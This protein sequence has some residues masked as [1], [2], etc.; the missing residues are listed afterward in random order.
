MTR[1]PLP[2]LV[3]CLAAGGLVVGFAVEPQRAWAAL[4]CAAL[5]ALSTSLFGAVFV[6]LANICGGTWHVAFRR[7]PE[8]MSSGIA[9]FGVVVV[10]LLAWRTL[11]GGT[12]WHPPDEPGTLWFKAWWLQP[13]FMV[14][15]SVG[16]VAVW[17]IGA[18]WLRS[19]SLA[20]DVRESRRSISHV[21][22][23]SAVFAALFAVTFSLAA[24]DWLMA[25]E[26]TWYST[27][28]GIYWFS[29]LMTGG[30]A[31]LILLALSLRDAGP[32]RQA[33]TDEH[34]HDLGKL[35][36]G[37]CCFWMYIWY[38]Q[39]MLIWYAHLPE[40][41][42]YFVPRLTGAWSVVFIVNVGLNWGL[43]FLL[44]LPRTSKRNP[45]LL[46]RVAVV[47]LV[48]RAVDLYLAA[49]PEVVGPYLIVGALE[50]AAA[51]LIAFVAWSL[52]S[53][54]FSS[55]PAVPAGSPLLRESLEYHA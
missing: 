18:T 46:R 32:L 52:W 44:L 9:P 47:V 36:F 3:A 6:A 12:A 43:P 25:L 20:E 45:T 54:S 4:Y 16:Y 14:A 31:T 26:P 48:G 30:L 27:V 28:W 21:Q 17:M 35:L 29:G 37:F 39:Y 22:R 34:L 49:Y 11:A 19:V 2:K 38:C 33:F 42:M 51:F 1:S 15:R 7:V 55:A 50:L 13:T 53:R 24:A 10:A 41:T 40:E 8:A 5:F 23:G